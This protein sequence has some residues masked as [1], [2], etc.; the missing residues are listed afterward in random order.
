[1]KPGVKAAF[2][3]I[4]RESTG[5]DATAGARWIEELG[6]K[7]RYALGRRVATF[8]VVRDKRALRAHIRDHT[9]KFCTRA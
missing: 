6:A 4:Y 3:A 8:T 2:V 9:G 7:N 1:M 5:S